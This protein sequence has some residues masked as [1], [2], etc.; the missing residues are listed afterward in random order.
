MRPSSVDGRALCQSHAECTSTSQLP[1]H[2]VKAWALFNH[3]DSTL[4]P[5]E[6]FGHPPPPNCP[7]FCT[8]EAGADI[9]GID[10]GTTNSC[11]SVLR[12][13]KE[14]P[15]AQ[16]SPEFLW[17]GVA[18]MEGA[19]PKVIENSGSAAFSFAPGCAVKRLKPRLRRGEGMRTTPSIVG[20]GEQR[21]ATRTRFRRRGCV[22][23]ASVCFSWQTSV[24]PLDVHAACSPAIALS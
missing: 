18:V 3:T 24:A 4:H 15:R 11:A 13:E 22:P 14:W 23:T 8:R 19:T 7:C 21:L 20:F 17:P 5:N 16:K 6:G 9:I 1:H 12:F 2:E 10:L